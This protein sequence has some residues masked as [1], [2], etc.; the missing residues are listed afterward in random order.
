MELAAVWVVGAEGVLS[1]RCATMASD[2]IRL[3]LGASSSAVLLV[4]VVVMMSKGASQR[5]FMDA[6]WRL[7]WT[8]TCF[9]RAQ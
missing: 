6:W 3:R 4:L 9:L 7:D 2:G 8:P 1:D 5:Q